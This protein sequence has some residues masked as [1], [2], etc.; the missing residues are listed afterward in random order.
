M[1]LSIGKPRLNFLSF[2]ECTKKT[3][4]DRAGPLWM[5]PRLRDSTSASTLSPALIAV[6]S[7]IL[8][9][10]FITC[11]G[12]WDESENFTKLGRKTSLIKQQLVP[13]KVKE[14]CCP[15]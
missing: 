13:V 7:Y 9:S 1:Y 14:D 4:H 3:L 11:P 8:F 15:P 10:L 2:A 6:S 5:S 12:T